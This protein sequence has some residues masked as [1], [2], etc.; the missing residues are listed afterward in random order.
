MENIP[1]IKIYT[2]S[3]YCI[4]KVSPSYV[5]ALPKKQVQTI[6]KEIPEG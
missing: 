5:L 3:A 4:S 1:R 6:C 2:E